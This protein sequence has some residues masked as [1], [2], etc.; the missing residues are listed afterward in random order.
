MAPHS[1]MYESKFESKL[2]LNIGPRVIIRMIRII[3]TNGGRP[4]MSAVG[5]KQTLHQRRFCNHLMRTGSGI[6]E[7]HQCT[8]TI[9]IAVSS[10]HLYSSISLLNQNS[11]QNG[12]F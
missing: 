5:I 3:D 6:F 1:M 4:T 9:Y 7:S 10:Q 2:A 8:F 12:K 11:N